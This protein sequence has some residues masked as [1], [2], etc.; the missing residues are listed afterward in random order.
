MKMPS[1]C[2]VNAELVPGCLSKKPYEK[3]KSCLR[4]ARKQLL[5]WFSKVTLFVAVTCF[6]L[7][8]VGICARDQS[9]APLVFLVCR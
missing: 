9:E 8:T 7:C 6:L 2:R 5:V 1:Q 3:E 4:F